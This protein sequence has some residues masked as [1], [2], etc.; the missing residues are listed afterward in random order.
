MERQ[1]SAVLRIEAKRLK[2]A[3]VG[4]LLLLSSARDRAG[5]GPGWAVVILRGLG[6]GHR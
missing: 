6:R 4:H 1:D 3:M 5:D 2:C